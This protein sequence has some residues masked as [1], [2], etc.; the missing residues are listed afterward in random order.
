MTPRA[1][2]QPRS[3]C[4]QLGIQSRP[5]PLAPKVTT[6]IIPEKPEK[7]NNIK[8]KIKL[9]DVSNNIFQREG[10]SQVPLHIHV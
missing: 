10:N 3:L 9:Y 8:V 2:A 1:K 7:N 5:S 6:D 4:S